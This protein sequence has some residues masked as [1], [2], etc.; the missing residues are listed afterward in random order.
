MIHSK[1]LV[2]RMA[3]LQ[4]AVMF[5]ALGLV[6]VLSFAGVKKW[7]ERERDQNLLGV[8]D[9]TLSALAQYDDRL[10]A[11]TAGFFHEVEEHRPEG[12][13]VVVIETGGGTL[14]TVGDGPPLRATKNGNC[15]DQQEFRVC[16]RMKGHLAIL[17]GK[18]M[19]ADA[20]TIGRL[21]WLVL[22]IAALVVALIGAL[23]RFVA[24]RGLLPLSV[25]SS[26][27]AAIEP[28]N[29]ERLGL[30][31][32]LREI[33]D[34]AIRFDELLRRIDDAMARERRFSAQAS[35]EL[36]TPLTVLRGELELSLREPEV[37]AL[38]ASRALASAET[39]AR[40]LDVLLLFGRAESRFSG[41]RPRGR[42]SLRSRTR[43]AGAIGLAITRRFVA[44]QRGATRGGA[45][46]RRAASP[47]ACGDEPHRQRLQAHAQDRCH[48]GRRPAPID[49]AR[50]AGGRRRSRDFSGAC[51]PDLRAIFPRS[52]FARAK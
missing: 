45:G 17:A 34:V 15:E 23:S 42:E 3:L 30:G 37:S 8:A 51:K 47:L 35:H 18:S 9:R 22:G 2:G 41:Q 1:T 29:G 6:V 46:A 31:S 26:R 32:G 12:T 13:R 21:F 44:Y 4:V 50:A 43:L 19:A 36:R 20:A 27:L 14:A 16:T 38:A 48:R 28:G 24:R 39:M 25:L 5:V 11:D 7:L 33:D 49:N 40:L 52:H 10:F